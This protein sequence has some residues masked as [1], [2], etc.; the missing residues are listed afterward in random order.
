MHNR[1]AVGLHVRLHDW[2][3]TA[4]WAIVLDGIPVE[5]LEAEHGFLG[6]KVVGCNLSTVLGCVPEGDAALAERQSKARGSGDTDAVE[7]HLCSSLAELQKYLDVS[8]GV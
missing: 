7:E 5:Q 3:E 1:A 6:L 4:R 2:V 8:N